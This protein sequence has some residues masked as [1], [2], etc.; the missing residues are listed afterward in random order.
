MLLNLVNGL[1]LRCMTQKQLAAAAGVNASLLSQAINGHRKLK[2]EQRQRIARILRIDE[3][4][5]FTPME[6]AW[7]PAAPAD[8]AQ[9]SA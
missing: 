5:A 1:R 2:S 6:R 3:E 8:R 9:P 4:W 7:V